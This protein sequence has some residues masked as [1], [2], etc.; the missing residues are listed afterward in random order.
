M[1]LFKNPK[2]FIIS[3]NFWGFC[4]LFWNICLFPCFW[5]WLM[6]FPDQQI[7]WPVPLSM[8]IACKTLLCHL[9]G[10]W[11]WA[12]S[13]MCVSKVKATFPFMHR[14]LVP[15]GLQSRQGQFIY[16]LLLITHNWTIRQQHWLLGCSCDQSHGNAWGTSVIHRM[17]YTLKNW[18]S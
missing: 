9:I 5:R 6:D 17:L 15:N 12:K 18:G 2:F 7:S 10:I 11:L 4:Y 1:K 8:K 16:I 14:T 13:E 3:A